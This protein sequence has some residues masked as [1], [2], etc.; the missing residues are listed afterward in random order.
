M[1]SSRRQFL[2]AALGSTAVLSFQGWAPSFLLE[3][4]AASDA[5]A[6][7]DNIL[8][9]VQLSGGNDG[10]N[11]VIPFRDDAYYRARPK[12]G[13]PAD[14]VLKV[15]DDLGLHPSFSGMAELLKMGQLAVVQGVGYPDPNRSHFESM[16]IWHTCQR[17]EERSD[18][19]WIGRYLDQRRDAWGA[20]SPAIHL[21]DQKQPYALA[22]QFVRTPSISSVERFRL[23]TDGEK[24]AATAIRT[25]ADVERSATDGLFDFVRSSTKSA[26]DV[27]DRIESA[28][29]GYKA[30]V[31][32]PQSGLAQNLHTV[33]QLIDAGLKT[34]VYYL[35][36][37]GF[38]THSQ[39]P[40]AHAALLTEVSAGIKA[41]MD[42]L[43]KHGHSQRVLLMSF[44]EF[45]RRVQ[46]NASEGTDHGA[47][48]PVFLAGAKVKGGIIG[49]HPSLSDLDDGD[50]KHHTDF[51]AVFASVLEK[52]L[53]CESPGILGGK[54]QR[55]ETV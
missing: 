49:K 46:E 23:Q 3:A 18:D 55:I 54:Y 34:R 33:A 47:A 29:H 41:F 37:D 2:S 6:Q 48:A 40:D 19:G 43:E 9:V 39:Q 30:A 28:R 17:K 44:S 50:L 51:R 1:Q 5:K 7:D 14:R 35:E 27:S 10:L 15:S 13:I 22:A 20:D 42:D 53:N 52:W 24:T 8:V 11:T 21:G 38:D 26:L 32:Y 16:D 36:L 12:L 31:E 25:L 4:A 45:G